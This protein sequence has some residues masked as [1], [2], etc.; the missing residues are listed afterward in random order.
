V[1]PQYQA[2]QYQAP[3]YQAPQYPTSQYPIPQQPAQPNWAAPQG[4]EAPPAGPEALPTKRRKSVVGWVALGVGVFTIMAC[5]CGIG[6][7][8]LVPNLR[9]ATENASG[10][11]SASPTASQPAGTF[12]TSTAAA[13]AAGPF[14][15]TPAANFPAGTAGITLPKAVKTGVFSA[16]DVSKALASVRKALIAARLDKPMVVSRNP[17]PFLKLMAVDARA[18]LRKDFSAVTF[19]TY[20]TQTAKG[21]T[22]AAP[23][24]RVKGKI[25]YRATKASDGVRVLE[26]VTNFVWAYPFVAAKQDPGDDIVIVHDKVTW[27]V[28]YVNDVTTSARGLWVDTAESYGWNIDCA[29][30][31]KGY[32]APGKADQGTGPGPT[33]DPDA[34]YDP[35][36]TIDISDSC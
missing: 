30:F 25:T 9:D 18:D 29:Q 22:L 17:E 11:P 2:P 27:Q 13:A 16:A 10:D 3:Q 12:A 26:V 33:E 7:V 36:H 34:M 32:I 28:P 35:E 20:A 21:S 31:D 6:A 4:W 23:T 19:A 14:A 15:G 24:P 5:L 1:P 8:F